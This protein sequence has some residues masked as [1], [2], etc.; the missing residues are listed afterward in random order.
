[1]YIKKAFYSRSSLVIIVYL[2]DLTTYPA[3]NITVVGSANTEMIFA[4][5][6][7]PA[8]GQTVMGSSFMMS[9][10]GRGSNQ[11]VTAARA[12]ADVTFIGRLG[13][14]IFGDLALKFLQQNG[15]NTSFVIRDKSLSSG[16][17]S[18]VQDE[19][20]ESSVTVSSGANMNLSPED[21]QVARSALTQTDILLLQLEIPIETVRYAANI[22]RSSGIKVILDPAPALPVSDELLKSVSI[23][24]PD[25]SEAER[26][27][28]ITITDERSAELAGRILLERGL[29]RVIITLRSKG[30]MVI[31]N[32]GAEHV[33]GFKVGTVNNM[34]M[35]DVFN[36]A[37][38]VG[39]AEE[40]N[41][42]EAVLFANAAAAI[43]S[44]LKGGQSSIPHR[45][46]ILDFLK[47]AKKTH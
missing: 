3:M 11:A 13:E 40:K 10:G 44:S 25:A 42:Y 24:T 46:E 31:D 36:G 39:L 6:T 2:I 8:R 37:L 5:K 43:S 27:T 47:T 17:S 35:N 28:G 16:V 23:L 4:S 14:D 20:G 1:L 38:A 29:N 22:A 9:P 34:V 33:P 32:G 26:L 19:N 30:A 41:F 21:I 18:I 12:G 15:I 7:I 45:N